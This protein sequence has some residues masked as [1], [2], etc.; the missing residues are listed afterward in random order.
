MTDA[1][2]ARGAGEAAGADLRTPR[3]VEIA[4]CEV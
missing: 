2:D 4:A 1:R 3:E